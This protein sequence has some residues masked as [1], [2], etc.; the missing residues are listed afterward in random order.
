MES[1]FLSTASDQMIEVSSITHVCRKFHEL[2]MSWDI[3]I[4]EN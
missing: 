2:H 1:G 4:A 3:K